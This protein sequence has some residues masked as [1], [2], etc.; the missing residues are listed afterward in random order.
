MLL[1]SLTGSAFGAGTFASFNASTTNGSST[2]STGTLVLSNAKTSGGT[3]LSA[4]SGNVTDANDGTG[5]TAC[6]N[7]FALTAA[8]PGD[9]ASADLTLVNAGSVNASTIAAA[10]SACTSAIVGTYHGTD[11]TKICDSTHGFKIQ[12]QEYTSNTRVIANAVAKCIYPVNTSANCGGTASAANFAYLGALLST[13]KS[14]ASCSCFGTQVAGLPGS[15]GTRYISLYIL[16]PDN[17]ASVVNTL[18]DN[19]YQGLSASFNVTWTIT[20]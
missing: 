12:V 9:V 10:F 3:C 11:A 16:L 17:G 6:D 4:T 13:T 18:T 2:F 14:S 8:K 7:L 19:A 20:Q 1:V 5:N 15:N